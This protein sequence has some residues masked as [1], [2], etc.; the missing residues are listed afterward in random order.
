M[1]EKEGFRAAAFAAA[2]IIGLQSV[3]NL[4][5]DNGFLL[6]PPGIQSEEDFLSRCT[7]C[8]KCIEACPYVAIQAATWQA[9]IA[10]GTPV[11]DAASQAC[12][13]CHDFPC[14]AA[15]PTGALRDVSKR[16][17]VRMGTAVIDEELCI[18]ISKSIRCEVCYR[19]CPLIG[20]AITCEY[21]VPEAGN[22][23]FAIFAPVVDAEKCTGC[24]IC[25]QRCYVRQPTTAIRIEEAQRNQ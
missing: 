8:G 3:Y 20:E 25:V 19:S 4:I 17:D 24:G 12:Q 5:A 22:R 14:V 15:C 13:L 10:A 11:I 9:G 7:S 16:E 18:A 23:G 2:G 21:R 6:R 1:A